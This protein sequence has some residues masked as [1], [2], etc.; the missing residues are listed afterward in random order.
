MKNK[1]KKKNKVLIF[2]AS[3]IYWRRTDTLKKEIMI[4]LKVTSISVNTVFAIPK[5]KWTVK[6]KMIIN[7]IIERD[8][9]IEL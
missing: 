9:N 4:S 7:V 5:S 6:T 1:T 8:K 3:V 2:S